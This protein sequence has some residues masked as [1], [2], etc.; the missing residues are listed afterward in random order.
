M[1]MLHDPFVFLMAVRGFVNVDGLPFPFAA[2]R[3]KFVDAAKVYRFCASIVW[4]GFLRPFLFLAGKTGALNKLASQS[5]SR[6]IVQAQMNQKNFFQSLVRAHAT[7]SPHMHDWACAI[8]CAQTNMAAFACR[9]IRRIASVFGA[10]AVPPSPYT[11]ACTLACISMS[12]TLCA[13]N[14]SACTSVAG[15]RSAVSTLERAYVC[16]PVYTLCVCVCTCVCV[17]VWLRVCTFPVRSHLWQNFTQKE[18]YRELHI[19]YV[20]T[21]VFTTA[22][23]IMHVLYL[24]WLNGQCFKET[25]SAFFSYMQTNKYTHTFYQTSSWISPSMQS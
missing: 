5:F 18:F 16:I 19:K 7:I 23:K 15:L 13:H 10:C 22:H 8:V 17:C 3:K 24:F 12:V 25:A 2:K 11:R 21:N 14:F 1:L 4:T 9:H 6:E 20:E